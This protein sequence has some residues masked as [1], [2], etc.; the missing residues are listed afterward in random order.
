MK[1]SSFIRKLIEYDK[2]YP[3]AYVKNPEC[4]DMDVNY[5]FDGSHSEYLTYDV[6]KHLQK[7]MMKSSTGSKR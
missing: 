4:F 6:E 2:L 1:L 3:N 7:A 5:R